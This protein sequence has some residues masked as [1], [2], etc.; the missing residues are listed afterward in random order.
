MI[1]SNGQKAVLLGAL[2]FGGATLAPDTAAAQ[3]QAAAD[4]P[5]DPIRQFSTHVVATHYLRGEA[6]ETHHYFKPLREGALQGLVFR[7]AV[8][9]A[10]LIEVEWAISQEVWNRLPDWQKDFWHPR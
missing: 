5:T 9:G 4:A 10:P 6:Y 7:H 2:P 8:E 1:R 3:R